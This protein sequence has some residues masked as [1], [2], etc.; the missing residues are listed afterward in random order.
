MLSGKYKKADRPDEGTRFSFTAKHSL[1]R[2]WHERGFRIAEEVVRAAE[3]ENKPPALLALAWLLH[4]RR[5]TSVIVGAR[6]ADQLKEN[7]LAGEWDLG[8]ELWEKLDRIA[9][10]D[11]GYPKQWMDATFP[12]TF[13]EEEF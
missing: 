2:Y 3:N 6:K 7:L 9:E 4:D 5:V 13:G 8:Q 12:D 1:P 11:Q 10:F